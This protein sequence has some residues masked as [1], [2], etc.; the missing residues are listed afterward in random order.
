VTSWPAFRRTSATSA[1]VIGSSSTAKIFM[2][3]V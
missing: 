2:A 3:R 1:S